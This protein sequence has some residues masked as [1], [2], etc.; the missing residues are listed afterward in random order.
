V[1]FLDP[2][3]A[4]EYSSRAASALMVVASTEGPEIF[5]KYHALLFQRQPDEN[6]AG[7]S[8]STLVDWAV[9]AG[10]DRA[11]VEQGILDAQYQQWAFN[12]ADQMSKEGVTGTPTVMIDGKVVGR[13]NPQEAVQALL[14]AIGAGGSSSPSGSGQ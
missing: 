11:T 3:S 8:N 2:Q 5:Q 13:G 9:E 6:T 10:A 12:A 14:A 4:N 7:P 1:S